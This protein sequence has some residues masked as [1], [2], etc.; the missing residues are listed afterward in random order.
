[1]ATTPRNISLRELRMFC[2]AAEHESFRE[3]ADRLFVTASAISHQ[4]KHLESQ[5]DKKLFARTSRAIRLTED[6]QSLYDDVQPL[7]Q[8]LDVVVA[9]HGA[10]PSSSVLKISVQPFF[11]SELFVPRLSRFTTLHPE[12]DI[13]VET[14]DESAEKHPNDV[15]LSIRIFSTAPKNLRAERLSPL[16]LVPACSP[17]FL[18]RVRISE[19]RIAGEFPLIVHDKR[20][21][22]WSQWARSFG[23]TLPRDST[24]VR[25]DSM[26]AVVRAAERGLGAALV[27][28]QLSDSWF[29]ASSLVKL[30]EHELVT[31]DAYYLIC[32]ESALQNDNVRLF[33]EWVLQTFGNRR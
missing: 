25:L 13:K 33:H 2:A 27:P 30:F 32:E 31:K 14:S 1:M 7:I 15:D 12:I 3:A 8:K 28:L 26:I 6:G 9:S 18:D 11:A 24:T 20:P 19:K 5:L 22:A 10:A 23:M 4:I 29:E 16:R 21:Q 17:E